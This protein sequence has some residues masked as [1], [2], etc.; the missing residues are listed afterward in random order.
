MSQDILAR[1]ILLLNSLEKLSKELPENC[2]FIVLK[3]A[4]LLLS[5]I[6]D[7][8]KRQMSDLDIL[9]RREQK[10]WFYSALSKC[11][12]QKM[13]SS[14]SA[15][16]R[17]NHKGPPSIIDLHFSIRAIDSSAFW[18]IA[19]KIS[20]KAMG[21]P[22]EYNFIHII[23]HALLHHGN[24]SFKEISDLEGICLSE[25][26][27]N[28]LAEFAHKV[29]NLAR[30]NKTAFLLYHAAKKIW[31]IEPP[32]QH[33]SAGERVFYRFFEFTLSKERKIN[34]YI[35][36]LFYCPEIFI[37]R[38]FPPKALLIENHGKVWP[39]NYIKYL[40]EKILNIAG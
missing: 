26:K 18:N 15:W 20:G 11:G 14:E 16:F 8:S 23:H 25:F 6:A 7:P 27:K 4:W 24:L 22:A 9:I 17:E 39:L 32:K 30:R 19:E 29:S 37:R 13:P 33:F 28:R 10:N 5:Q 34:E 40:K 38:F 31:G 35:L 12:F 36:E 2:S 3:G 1:N 21:L